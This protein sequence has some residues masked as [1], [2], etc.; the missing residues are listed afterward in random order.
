MDFCLIGFNCKWLT[1]A[2][3]FCDLQDPRVW[4]YRI[5]ARIEDNAIAQ[6]TVQK[7]A[8]VTQV[9]AETAWRNAYVNLFQPLPSAWKPT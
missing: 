7:T 1:V 4:I 5:L 8:E 6:A 3:L 2:N 9:D